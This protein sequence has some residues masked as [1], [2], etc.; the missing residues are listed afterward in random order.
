LVPVETV[1]WLDAIKYCNALS[2]KENL[3]PFY[4]IDGDRVSVPDWD[5]EGYR[6]P[7]EAEWEYACRAGTKTKYWF[8]DNAGEL[9][10]HA[11]FD[12]NSQGRTQR[13]RTSPENP[14]R[15]HDMHGNVWE[16][17]WDWYGA[18]YYNSPS[19]S[20]DPT[21]PETGDGRVLRGG[22][23]VQ[24]AWFLRSAFRFRFTPAYRLN[25]V[26]FRLA[27]TYH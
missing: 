5:G 11:W 19:S 7:T 10:R 3:K 14:F 13:V 8:G 23:W 16:W 2:E 27:R 6:L 22:S 24:L 21:G 18:N 4:R 15:L 12:G 25:Y 26:G 20:I 9:G 17:C 1:S